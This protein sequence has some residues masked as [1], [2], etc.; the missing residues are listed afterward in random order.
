MQIDGIL[1]ILARRRLRGNLK[2]A[3]LSRFVYFD[4]VRELFTQKSQSTKLTF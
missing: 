2:I 3:A 1:Y 4:F